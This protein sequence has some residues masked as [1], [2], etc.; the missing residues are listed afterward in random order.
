MPL[1]LKTVR[2]VCKFCQ[3]LA[4]E[5]TQLMKVGIFLELDTLDY[6]VHFARLLSLFIVH[7]FALL[8]LAHK[9]FNW[10][11]IVQHFFQNW[12]TGNIYSYK[13]MGEVGE[14]AILIWHN[15]SIILPAEHNF[16]HNTLV[17][18]VTPECILLYF[19][20]IIRQSLTCLNSIEAELSKYATVC[21]HTLDWFESVAP[22]KKSLPIMLTRKVRY[23]HNFVWNHCNLSA[24]FTWSGKRTK[25][26]QWK[27]TGL[28][29]TLMRYNVSSSTN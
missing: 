13:P 9:M 23:N 6:P 15:S 21:V 29:F 8:T 3:Q 11:I 19:S 17:S 24:F 12:K 26:F 4:L 2:G 28:P 25:A 1:F 10:I 14:S 7:R 20:S 16:E 18:R 22:R 5:C 27:S